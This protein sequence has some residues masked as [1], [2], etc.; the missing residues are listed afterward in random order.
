MAR[1]SERSRASRASRAPLG[2]HRKKSASQQ[3]A[4]PPKAVAGASLYEPL[5]NPVDAAALAH[6]YG[7]IADLARVRH[8]KRKGTA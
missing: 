5:L 6:S 2:G 4:E 3:G 7:V 8:P 1:R